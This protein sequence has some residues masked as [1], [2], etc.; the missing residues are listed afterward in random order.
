MKIVVGETVFWSLTESKRVA[1]ADPVGQN[2]DIIGAKSPILTSKGAE[3]FDWYCVVRTL[4]RL[5]AA[6]CF[7]FQIQ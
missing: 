7:P 1:I 2:L 5:M 6:L 4:R 3:E